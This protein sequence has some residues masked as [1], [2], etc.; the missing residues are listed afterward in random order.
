MISIKNLTYGYKKGQDILKN[1]NLEIKDNETIAIM[2]KNGSGKSTL[3]K[4]ISGIIKIRK[5]NILIDGL[6]ISDNKNKDKI[7]SEIGIVFQNPENQI[8]FN[9]IEDELSF[10]LKGLNREELKERINESL[11]KVHMEDMIK[12]DLYELSLGQKQ[13]IIISEI[14]AKK[15]KYI[16]FD[17]PT[18]MIDSNGKE[19]IYNILKQLKKEGYTIIY[20]TNIA[21]EMLLADRIVIIENG[22]IVDIIS[23]EELIDRIDILEKHDIKIPVLLKIVQALKEEGINIDLNEF[24][25]DELILKIKGIVKNEK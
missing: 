24:S 14:L 25:V 13:R 21:D 16:I 4:L 12:E 9:N 5:G 15:P 3:G 22:E 17:E 19:E 6:D 8:I 20:I 7:I 11:K 10:S 23:K 2:G 1:I 18:T